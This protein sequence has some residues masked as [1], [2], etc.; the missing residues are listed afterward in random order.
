MRS[1]P[2]DTKE[3]QKL[4][5][6]LVRQLWRKD[7]A[8]QTRQVASAF[9][10]V[11]RHLFVPEV[12]VEDAYSDQVIPLKFADDQAISSSSQPGMMAIMLEQLALKPGMRVLEIGAGSGYNAALIAH[13]VGENGS[14]ISIDIDDDLVEGARANLQA[15]MVNNVQVLRAD[16]AYGYVQSAPYDRIILTVASADVT[17][18]WREQLAAHGRLVLPLILT[19]DHQISAALEYQED[20]LTVVNLVPC[21]FMT[22]RGDFA[23]ADQDMWQVLTLADELQIYVN[24]ATG[25][26]GDDLHNLLEMEKTTVSTGVEL[27]PQTLFDGRLW[28]SLYQPETILARVEGK[29]RQRRII[30]CIFGNRSYCTTNGLVSADGLA[31]WAR[32]YHA[33]PQKDQDNPFELVVRAH[34]EAGGELAQR[35]VAVAQAWDGAGRP[36]SDQTHVAI[37]PY[38]MLVPD[39]PGQMILPRET[40]RIVLW[41]D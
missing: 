14:V 31:L 23:M 38:G 32:R 40:V 17:P 24:T 11:P 37:Y 9:R 41:F 5:E 7:R 28:M 8:I 26:T 36:G 33:K 19:Q 10:A 4:R 3:T 30:P 2:R 35:L 6:K 16:G 34:G 29:L 20:V 27:L 1:H 12:D 13:I 25:V 15:A 18:A 21:R 22:L 39:R